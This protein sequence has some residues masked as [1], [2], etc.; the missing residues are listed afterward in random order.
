MKRAPVIAGLVLVGIAGLGVAIGGQAGTATT[1]GN[2]WP[3][4]RKATPTSPALTPEEEAKTFS[5]PPG[6]HAELVASDPMIE[7]PILIDFDA[8]G[9]MYV[10]EMRSYM[11]DVDGSNSREPV[12]RI[13]RHEDTDGHGKIEG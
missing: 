8:N 2:P 13:S 10:L 5:L 11:R 1:P 3:P 6:Y 4:A 12:S 7:S 9:R